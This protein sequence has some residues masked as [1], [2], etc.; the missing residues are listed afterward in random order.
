MKHNLFNK[1]RLAT[2]LSLV[3]GATAFAS[4]SAVAAEDE[5][6]VIEVTGI[7][8][9]LI[10]AM[11]VKRGSGG[12]V[13]SIT[14]EDM[15][16]FPDTNLAESLQRIT[17]VSI[18]RS[19]GEG[20]QVTVRGFGPEFNMVTL[21]GRTMPDSSVWYGSRAYDF[22]NLSSDAVSSVDVHKTS[23]AS[24]SSGGMGSTINIGTAKPLQNPGLR[25]SAGVKALVDTSVR[26]GGVKN[27]NDEIT[28]E[29]SGLL[30]WTDESEVFGVG[31]NASFSERHSSETGSEVNNWSNF[32]Y[33]DYDPAT[34][35]GG[36]NREVNEEYTDGGTTYPVSNVTNRPADGQ[37]YQFPSDVAY[38]LWDRQRERT[39]AQLT[40]QYRPIESVTATL[41]YTYSHIDKK[42]Y[43]TDLSGWYD[44][45]LGEAVFTTG[46]NPTPE[47]Y[48]ENRNQNGPRDV[49]LKQMYEGFETRNKSVGFNVDWQ[50]NDQLKLTL[51]AHDSESVSNPTEKFGHTLTVGLGS[52]VHKSIGAKYGS[53]GIPSMQVVFDDCDSRPSKVDTITGESSNGYNCNDRLDV[54]EIGTTMM[55]TTY[56][57][58]VNEIQQIKL[59]GTFEFEEAG[60]I[61]FGVD[62]R[63]MKNNWV[64]SN[65]GNQ[66][67]GG[68]SAANA[69]ELAGH[70]FLEPIDF[71]DSL[72]D[73]SVKDGWTTGVRGD[74]K[75]IGRYAAEV[76]DLEFGR[77]PNEASNRTIEEDIIAVYGQFNYEGEIAD[78]PYSARFGLRYED[79]TSRS[80]AISAVP[81]EVRWESNN[82]FNVIQGDFAD[83]QS[84]FVENDYD[85]VLP[86]FDFNIEVVEDVMVR[87]ATSKTIARPSY[88]NLDAQTS[89][90]GGP[91]PLPTILSEQSIASG[92]RNNPNL[93]P[94]ES[95]NIDLSAEWYYDES[96]YVSVGYFRKDVSNFIGSDP[97][98]STLLG[99]RD[100]SAGPRAQQAI[101]D[102]A[103]LGITNPD[104]TQL[105]SM[106][107]AN[108]LGV[109][110]NSMSAAE[111]E[112]AINISA[113]ANDPLMM[114]RYNAPV[115]THD[116]ELS[117]LEF[118]IQHFFGESGF[119]FQANYT[120]V[121][122]DIEFDLSSN[123]TQFALLGLSDTANLVLIY[124]KD[125]FSARLAYNWR[126]AFLNNTA[127]TGTEPEFT[128]DYSQLDFNASYQATEELSVSFTAINLTGEDGRKYGRNENQFTSGYENEARYEFGARYSF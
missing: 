125:E 36:L 40:L 62:S 23:K 12:V 86:N 111:F 43:G 121:D 63:S 2:S 58:N 93:V 102:L 65:T 83:A 17:G 68:W 99:L 22:Q 73:Y 95:V 4:T 51:D 113:N 92:S 119:G 110:Y 101:T 107:A 91:G 85:H 78:L 21:N 1:T 94:M 81:A 20:S 24:I 79:T 50:V 56:T 88:G 48:I 14:A 90:T 19:N 122:G 84:Y 118:A 26:N 69:G 29:I 46:L 126:D 31:L 16:K 76:Y 70:G 71:N 80:S 106:V 61:D 18:D 112:N 127:R 13:D 54:S 8:G 114:F 74:A 120:Y 52:N 64:S 103:A 38:R 59:D 33:S 97:I 115:N 32:A 105:F 75:E 100:P 128:A 37:R 35:T 57:D 87:F 77:N 41:D 11:D 66:T 116:T 28:P 104:D 53:T 30:S 82:D 25:V 9:S 27:Y 7:R 44:S 42:Q 117:G 108:E 10:R 55:Q 96:N 34:Q 123:S 67:M 15:G 3:L 5:V 45:F 89:V 39:N 109:D 72:D 6:E 124:E 47:V 49:A 60:S 98:E